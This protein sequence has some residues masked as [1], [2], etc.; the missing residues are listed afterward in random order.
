MVFLM[1]NKID[2]MHLRKVTDEMHA[3]FIERQSLDGGFLVSAQSGDSVLAAF[4]SVGATAAGLPLTS[5]ELAMLDR[6]VGVTVHKRTKEELE[7]EAEL[8]RRYQEMERRPS[9][10]CCVIA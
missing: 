8:E 5:H 1:G 3:Q 9:K 2:L 7:E 6:P 10:G 4:H